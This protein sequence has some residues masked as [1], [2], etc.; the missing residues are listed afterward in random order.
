[1]RIDTFEYLDKG[2]MIRFL[3][4][5][6]YIINYC[7]FLIFRFDKWHIRNGCHSRPYK[8]AVASKINSL[9][10]KIVVELG[11]GLGDILRLVQSPR[12]IGYDI[13]NSVVRAARVKSLFQKI[14]YSVGDSSNVVECDIDVLIMVNWIH[15]LSPNLLE[16]IINEFLPRVNYFVFDSIDQEKHFMY[17]YIH[18]FQFM[19]KYAKVYDVFRVHGEPRQFIIWKTL[20]R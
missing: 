20:C 7:L 14:I 6:E 18:D 1:M 9:K 16:S 19:H 10:P 11:C 3:R 2:P 13:D 12:K 5:V 4:K 15:N 17:K 8:K